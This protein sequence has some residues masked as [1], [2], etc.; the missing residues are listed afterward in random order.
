MLP[1]GIGFAVFCFVFFFLKIY[2]RGRGTVGKRTARLASKWI[3]TVLSTHI[4]L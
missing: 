1:C 2:D 3:E 4:P